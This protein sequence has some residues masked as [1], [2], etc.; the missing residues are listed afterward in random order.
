LNGLFC[1]T[2]ATIWM[3]VEAG[4][5]F[6]PL[7][8]PFFALG[9]GWLA[10]VRKDSVLL[11]MGSLAGVITWLNLFIAW[12]EGDLQKF[13][14]VIDQ[15]PISIG[16]GF[17]LS[18]L[19]WWLMR[20]SDN[21][22][23]DYGQVV[24]LWLLRGTVVVLL[25]LSFEDSWSELAR[26]EY[27]FGYFAPLFVLLSGAVGCTLA[28]PSGAKALSPLLAYIAYFFLAFLWIQLGNVQ[29]DWLAAVTNIMLVV[30]GVWLIRRGIDDAVTQ[31]F[32]TGVG[33]LLLTA[34]LRYFDLIGDYIGGAVL[35]IIA[36]AVLFGAA[37]YWRSRIMQK[38]AGHV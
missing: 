2:L 21:A 23:R 9:A 12:I 11:F 27:T 5:D 14:L 38:E 29:A 37:R 7:S 6:F 26:E 20:R 28:R 25:L 13:R 24:H 32:Y 35:F 17:L 22:L 36:A 3:M 34:L 30:T 4:S 31:F 19:A 16:M 8:Y 18:G 15:I 10:W 33:V 1:L